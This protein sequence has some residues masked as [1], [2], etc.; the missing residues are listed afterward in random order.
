MRTLTSRSRKYYVHVIYEAGRTKRGGQVWKAVFVQR[1]GVI[2]SWYT[3]RNYVRFWITIA[4][5][6][7]R[8]RG[9]ELPR[10]YY[11]VLA[12]N[13]VKEGKL[14]NVL[15]IKIRDGEV[16]RFYHPRDRVLVPVYQQYRILREREMEEIKPKTGRRLDVEGIIERQRERIFEGKRQAFTSNAGLSSSL[17]SEKKNS[18]RIFSEIGWGSG[19][20]FIT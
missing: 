9:E 11:I 19:S 14:H 12:K 2:R 1:V 8:A 10:E 15:K 6:R 17:F 16:E 13:K 4:G 20:I 18:R 5:M 3:L 7:L